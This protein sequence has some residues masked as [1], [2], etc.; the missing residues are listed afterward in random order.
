MVITA[1]YALISFTQASAYDHLTS[2]AT[3]LHKR[4]LVLE[5]LFEDS[6]DN[7]ISNPL[8][9]AVVLANTII[10]KLIP[11]GTDFHHSTT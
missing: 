1:I 9:Q 11:D 5:T 6:Q 2:K 8:Y 3:S 7:I 10:D 4:A